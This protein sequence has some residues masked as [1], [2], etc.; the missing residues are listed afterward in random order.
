MILVRFF[1]VDKICK[2][3]DKIVFAVL[4]NSVNIFILQE[5]TKMMIL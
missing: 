2:I 3:M 5:N 4:P 1:D